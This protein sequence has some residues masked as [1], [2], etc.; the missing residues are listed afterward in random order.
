MLKIGKIPN[1]WKQGT[2][3]KIP[4]TGELNDC[5]NWKGIML[6]LVILN[7]FCKI[8]LVHLEPVI[9]QI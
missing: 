7:I 8:L 5:G 9:D 2:A 3:I 6:S 1:K 4:K